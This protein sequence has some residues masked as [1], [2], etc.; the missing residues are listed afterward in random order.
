MT[1]HNILWDN[2]FPKLRAYVK[3]YISKQTSVILRNDLYSIAKNQNRT[4]RQRTDCPSLGHRH[5]T[6]AR[7]FHLNNNT[8]IANLI[9]WYIDDGDDIKT[10]YDKRRWRRR[11]KTK[12]NKN[13]LEIDDT[14]GHL[15]LKL[16][17]VVHRQRAVFCMRPRVSLCPSTARR[18]H[19]PKARTHP[20][21]LIDRAFF[22]RLA[23]LGII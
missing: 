13:K 4:G 23:C 22:L 20:R 8:T 10:V 14:E 2:W 6:L 5:V 21:F 17:R 16:A 7:I 15:M 12:Q 1:L 18:F 9:Q 19:L 3:S 11:K